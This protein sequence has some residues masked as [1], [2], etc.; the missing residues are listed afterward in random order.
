M[1]GAAIAVTAIAAPV[2]PAKRFPATVVADAAIAVAD[3]TAAAAT[4]KRTALAVD[5]QL[6]YAESMPKT[7]ASIFF[8]CFTFLFLT[9][10]ASLAQSSTDFSGEWKLNPGRSE[11]GRLP[12]APATS[13]K[14]D[15][16][17][18]TITVSTNSADASAPKMLLYPLDGRT[19]KRK[20][21]DISYSTETKWEGAAMLANTIVAGGGK[22]QTIMERW[23]LSSSGATLTIRRT[24]V[25][26]RGETEALLVYENPTAHPAV[27]QQPAPP[28]AEIATRPTLA[29]ATKPSTRADDDFVVAAGT[30]MLL[31]LRNSVDTKHSTAGDRVYLQTSYPVFVNQQLVI[32]QGSYVMGTVVESERAGKVKG[33]AALNIRFD[34][35]TLPNGVTRDFRS[36]VGSADSAQTDEEGRIKGESG[37]GN[38]ARTVATTTAA[39]AGIGTLAGAAKGAP[40]KGLGVGSAAGAAAGLIGVLMTRGPDVI[41]H[42][43]TSVEMVLDRDIRFNADELS[44]WVR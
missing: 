23:K 18:S 38:D 11:L 27:T 20:S 42:A 1:A 5:A 30:R 9:T 15:Q 25:D 44:R 35:V 2:A 13:L 4:A 24:L 36:R 14:V 19:E 3:A 41:L 31:H 26:S 16:S 28:P 32:P 33:R 10:A 17:T 22:N 43:G 40:L 21:G 34:S 8:L 39:G 37:K 7:L 6:N 12:T 29:V